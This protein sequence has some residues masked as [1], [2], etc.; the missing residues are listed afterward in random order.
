L[1]I[2]V[3][4]IQGKEVIAMKRKFMKSLCW[5]LVSAMFVIGITP[6]VY[7]EF[8]P[9]ELIG[10]SPVDRASDLQKIQK[11]IE[12]KM[13]AER[14]KQLGFSPEEILAKVGQLSDAQ[15]HQLAQKL[16]DLKVGGDGGWAVLVAIIVIAAIIVLVIYL[17]G[18]RVVVR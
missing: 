11:V 6:R 14:L 13:V 9:S 8:S 10:L 18:H 5:Y 12:M 15:I 3:K 4:K 17:S 2:L 16:D 1:H 7:A